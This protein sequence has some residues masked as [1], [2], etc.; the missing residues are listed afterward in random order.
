VR[1]KQ[2]AFD[3]CIRDGRSGARGYCSA[4]YGQLIRGKTLTAIREPGGP[5]SR[6]GGLTLPVDVVVALQAKGPTIHEAARAV[7][8]AW[9]AQK[10]NG[11]K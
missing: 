3:G 4:H 2:C 9:A 10:K 11:R 7:L 8:V 5:T 1:V 6:L